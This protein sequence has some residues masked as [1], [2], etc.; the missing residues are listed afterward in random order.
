MTVKKNILINYSSQI[1]NS[2]LGLILSIYVA[3]VLGPNVRG[4]LSIYNNSLILM[5]TW[6]GLSLPTSIVYFI[7]SNSINKEKVINTIFFFVITSS[8]LVGFVL[9]SSYKYDLGWLF[10]PK[11]FQTGEWI[12]I[13]SLHFLFSQLNSVF[14]SILNAHNIFIPQAYFNIF[15]T[16]ISVSLW[17]AIYYKIT[18]FSDFYGF[19]SAVILT[20]ILVIPLLVFNIILIYKKTDVRIS[21]AF[22]NKIEISILVKYS[23]LVYLCNALQMLSYRMDLWFLKY[24]KDSAQTGIYSLAANI[25]Q[26]IWILPSS[27][28]VVL[29]SQLSKKDEGNHSD[30]V[31]KYAKISF[32]A[33]LILSLILYF[34][35]YY[36]VP[37]LFGD[38]FTDARIYVGI[39]LFGIV[40]F[41]ITTVI[42]TYNAAK[43]KIIYNLWTTMW[44]LAFSILFYKLLIPIY[45][46]VGASIASVISYNASN[47]YIF[48]IFYKNTGKKLWKLQPQRDE[49]Q[50]IYKYFNKKK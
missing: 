28:S 12:I 42:A 44:G 50:I 35:F 9:F 22:I 26:L 33:A 21:F 4:D 20:L 8:F 49:L 18:P 48:Y 30:I 6:V 3:R 32:Y 29:Y 38:K 17:A 24:Y 5:T 23:F 46:S 31:Y 13:F 36:T 25:S 45:G 43:N 14:S 34:L 27:I 11:N 39:L 7:N 41:S 47:V 40:P 16:F 19:K 10:F 1:I 15:I 37:I 2:I